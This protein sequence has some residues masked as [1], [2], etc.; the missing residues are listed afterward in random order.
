M[1]YRAVWY[2]SGSRGHDNPRSMTGRL[3]PAALA[4]DRRRIGG[5]IARAARRTAGESAYRRDPRPVVAIDWSLHGLDATADGRRVYRFA[6]LEELLAAVDR[7]AK[8]VAESTFESWDPGR[9]ERLVATAR[10]AGHEVYVFRPIH[11]ARARNRTSVEKSDANDARTIYTIATAS[12][13][14][15]YPIP[16]PD[17]AKT[18]ERSEIAREYTRLRLSGAKGALGDLAERLLG[19][20]QKLP[21]ELARALGNGKR[22]S[23]TLL[24][25]IGFASARAT[26]RARFEWLLGLHGS[27]YPTLLRSEVHHHSFRHARKRGV[28][29]RAYRRALRRTYAL[30]KPSRGALTE[31]VDSS[32]GQS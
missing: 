20:Y 2:D 22:Y 23:P 13:L 28:R 6:T 21:A 14:H 32:L 7:P 12:R 24:A 8:L 29:W 1:S 15:L 30:L 5:S 19:P 31:L 16:A 3:L 4:A 10:R 9:R 17:P 26:S 11:T 25:V 18:K 27:A